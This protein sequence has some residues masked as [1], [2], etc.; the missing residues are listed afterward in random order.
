VLKELIRSQKSYIRNLAELNNGLAEW[1]H[2]YE[3]GEDSDLIPHCLKK[4]LKFDKMD[5]Y[6]LTSGGQKVKTE[7]LPDLRD[8]IKQ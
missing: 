3:S 1:Y 2:K 6:C 8:L 7:N 4:H 5:F